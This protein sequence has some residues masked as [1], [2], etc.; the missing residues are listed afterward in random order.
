MSA[1]DRLKEYWSVDRGKD[2]LIGECVSWSW[3]STWRRVA[4]VSVR[5]DKALK[6]E[7]ATRTELSFDRGLPACLVAMNQWEERAVEGC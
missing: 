7:D 6:H 1:Y 4:V 2:D 5:W 3:G